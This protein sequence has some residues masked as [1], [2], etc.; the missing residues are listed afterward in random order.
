MIYLLCITASL[1]VGLIVGITI[2]ERSIFKDP[3]K[4]VKAT[5][6]C[7]M[8]D[9]CPDGCPSISPLDS[10]NDKYYN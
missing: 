3:R 6:K 9:D 2:T 1:L 10:R 8:C 5:G 4:W 7:Y